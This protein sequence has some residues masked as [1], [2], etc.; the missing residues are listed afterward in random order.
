MAITY[1][2]EQRIMLLAILNLG[3]ASNDEVE[4]DLYNFYQNNIYLEQGPKQPQ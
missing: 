1:H 2:R 3:L 4:K